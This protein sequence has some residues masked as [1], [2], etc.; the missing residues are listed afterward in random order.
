[1]APLALIDPQNGVAYVY[2]RTADGFRLYSTGPN[3]QDEGGQ[4]AWK[5]PGRLAH[6]ATAQFGITFQNSRCQR[7]L[8]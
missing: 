3:G 5:G 6:L 8:D 1:M 4:H 2:Q 7:T